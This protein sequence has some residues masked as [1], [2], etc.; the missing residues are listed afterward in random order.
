MSG[1][2]STL[3]AQ[4]QLSEPP[5]W[6]TFYTIARQWGERMDLTSARDDDTWAELL[7]LDAAEMIKA[8]LV[9]GGGS[10]VDVGAGVGAPTIPLLLADETLSATLVEPRRK[11]ATFLRSAI[12]ALELTSRARVLEE[13]IDPN[14]PA[15]DGAPFDLALSRATFSPTEWMRIG[16]AL[17][18]HV[19]V[20]TAGKVPDFDQTGALVARTDYA[21]PSTGAPRSIFVSGDHAP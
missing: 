8:G 11:R 20:F 12:G 16:L 4:A 18:A 15:V 6:E 1:A 3:C 13:R 9:V 17:A 21:V 2:V 5:G 19:V 10:L 7:F 14:Q